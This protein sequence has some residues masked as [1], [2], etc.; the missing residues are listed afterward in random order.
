MFADIQ[1]VQLGIYFFYHLLHPLFL[2]YF[3]SFLQFFQNYLLFLFAAQ[4]FLRGVRKPVESKYFL[5][6]SKVVWIKPVIILSGFKQLLIE[7]LCYFKS[8]FIPYLCS[9]VKKC[10]APY[11]RKIEWRIRNFDNSVL[12]FYQ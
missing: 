5:I 7:F 6:A 12:R 4:I 9:N 1:L 10:T 2:L 8:I 11:Y 3:L